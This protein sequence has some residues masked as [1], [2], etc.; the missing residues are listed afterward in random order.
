MKQM[1]RL[2]L[3]AALALGMG[4][5][6]T[7]IAA[8]C[9][10]GELNVRYFSNRIDFHSGFPHDGGTL[11]VT[12]G[13]IAIESAFGGGR[14][15]RFDAADEDGKPLPD[16]RY[17]WEVSFN[18]KQVQAVDR[19]RSGRSA[20]QRARGRSQAEARRRDPGCR[21]DR[22]LSRSRVYSGSFLIHGG[23]IVDPDLKEPGEAARD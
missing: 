23:S 8:A 4:I 11:T 2:G 15:P 7:G 12:G 1:I 21:A 5:S 16:G 17:N 18:P 10:P 19:G 13:L 14:G 6:A 9:A 3:R 20:E 22:Q